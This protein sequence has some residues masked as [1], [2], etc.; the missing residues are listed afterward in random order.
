MNSDETLC[1]I[2]QVLPEQSVWNEALGTKQK[3]WIELDGQRWLFKYA[4][5]NTG[6]D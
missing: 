5:D 4:R 6:E 1:Q 2:I 3:F